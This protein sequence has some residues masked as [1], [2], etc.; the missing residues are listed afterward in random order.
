MKTEFQV[1]IKKLMLPGAIIPEIHYFC[2][3]KF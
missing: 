2:C 3:S 1:F